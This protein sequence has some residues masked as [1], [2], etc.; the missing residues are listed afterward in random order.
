M[1]HHHSSLISAMASVQ[2]QLDVFEQPSLSGGMC[3]G[4]VS[5]AVCEDV[6]VFVLLCVCV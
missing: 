6:R 4:L 3:G 2:T 1:F 5:V